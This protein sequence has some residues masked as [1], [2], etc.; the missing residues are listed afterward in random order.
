MERT[1]ILTFSL[2]RAP[3]IEQITVPAPLRNPFLKRVGESFSFNVTRLNNLVLSSDA[4][5]TLPL[6]SIL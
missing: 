2:S 5:A 1:T 4:V 6:L 3:P